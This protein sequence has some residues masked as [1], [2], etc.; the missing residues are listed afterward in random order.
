MSWTIAKLFQNSGAPRTDDCEENGAMSHLTATFLGLPPRS[1]SKCRFRTCRLT[2]DVDPGARFEKN[3]WNGIQFETSAFSREICD[4]E[5]KQLTR[6]A[7]AIFVIATRNEFRES[8]NRTRYSSV[9]SGRTDNF[10]A[11]RRKWPME[12]FLVAG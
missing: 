12:N 5:D 6:S 10:L 2:A 7:P 8:K 9:T 1:S 3:S 11:L 4:R